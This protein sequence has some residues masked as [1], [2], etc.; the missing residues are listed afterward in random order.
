MERN[1]PPTGTAASHNPKHIKYTRTQNIKVKN[2][3]K[4]YRKVGENWLWWERLDLT[5]SMLR[6]IISNECTQINLLQAGQEI[7]GFTELDTTISKA[8]A[9]RYFGLI[10]SFIGQHLG[11][12]MMESLLNQAWNKNVEKIT[13]DTCDLDHPSAINFY[14]RHG[15]KITCI[16]TREAAD[17]RVSGILPVTAAPHIPI[18]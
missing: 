11:S 12:F 4:L 13:L 8:P 2:Y 18:N 14:K 3:R 5:D 10:P 9:I 7:V 17:P 15:F 1:T 6:K 16:E